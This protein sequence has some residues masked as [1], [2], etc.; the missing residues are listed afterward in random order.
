MF[1]FHYYHICKYKPSSSFQA[2]NVI[3]KQESLTNK[4]Q[5][6]SFQLAWLH[7]LEAHTVTVTVCQG[8][9]A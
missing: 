4:D 5:H 2:L 7:L 8:T 3:N 9:L 1:P 6:P